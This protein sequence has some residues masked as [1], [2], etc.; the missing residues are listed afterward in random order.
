MIIFNEYEKKIQPPLLCFRKNAQSGTAPG[1]SVQF[2][3]KTYDEASGSSQHQPEQ[4]QQQIGQ[5]PLLSQQDPR[6]QSQQGQEPF[7]LDPVPTQQSEK[8]PKQKPLCSHQE[9]IQQSQQP[10]Q[11]PVA[12]DL[13]EP[14]VRSE[15]SPA[16]AIPIPPGQ[17]SVTVSPSMT[18]VDT[19]VDDDHASISEGPSPSSVSTNKSLD[20]DEN[21]THGSEATH[22]NLNLPPETASV[23]SYRTPYHPN[24]EAETPL[25]SVQGN[26]SDGEET[27]LKQTL[28]TQQSESD[29]TPL[30]SALNSTIQMAQILN[31][32]DTKPEEPPDPC[33]TPLLKPIREYER[34]TGANPDVRKNCRQGGKRLSESQRNLSG[35]ASSQVIQEISNNSFPM[36][37]SE[38]RHLLS[39][40]DSLVPDECLE[41]TQRLDKFEVTFILDT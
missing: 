25:K 23:V 3:N 20:E 26:I 32:A 21:K 8:Q 11:E 2:S 33:E 39:I 17:N 4:S 36:V 13:E 7:L 10:E 22:H 6:H 37:P 29:E 5:K 12:P 18:I 19:T 35:P 24:D 31:T 40:S 1:S 30:K 34:T 28:N 41:A 14:I 38:D 15:K 27:H 16:F 9:H